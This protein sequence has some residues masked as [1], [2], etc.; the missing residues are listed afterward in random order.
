MA[1]QRRSH[2]EV[3]LNPSLNLPDN[4]HLLREVQELRARLAEAEETLLAIRSGDVDAIVV[5]GPGGDQLFTL[6]GAE[7]A[8]RALVEAMNEGAA[9][10]SAQGIVHYCNQRIADLLQ[11]PTEKIIGAPVEKLVALDSKEGFAALFANA[12]AGQPGRAELRLQAAEPVTAHVSLR[13]MEGDGPVTLCMV[14]TDLT[15]QKRRDELIAAGELAR[16][17]LASAADAIAVCDKDGIIIS[18]N[19]ALTRICGVNP[20]FQPFDTVLPLHVDERDGSRHFQPFS[21]A[22]TLAGKSFRGREASFRGSDGK[23][24]TLLLSGAQVSTPSGVAGC[25]LT[26][27]DITERKRA[28]EALRASEERWAITLQS[29][30][31]AVI[32]TDASGNI[33]FMNAL[34]EKL[35]GWTFG[36]AKSKQLDAVFQIIQEVTRIKPESPVNKV[37]R[38]GDVVGLA[39]HSLLIRRDGAE[40]PIE[41]SGAPIRNREGQIE[42]VVLVFHDVSEQRKMEHAVRTNDRLAVTGRLAATI[43]HEIHNPLDTVGSLLYIVQNTTKEEATRR[44]VS[45]AVQ[46]LSRITRMTQQMLTFQRESAQP[47]PVQIAEVLDSVLALYERKIESAAIHISKE[48]EVVR[49]ILAQPGELRQVFANVLGNA[50]EAVGRDHGKIR[51]RAY[52]SRDWR[53]RRPGVRVVVADNGRGIPADIRGKIFEP[54]FTTKGE[55]GTGLGLWITSDIIRKHDGTIRL[56]SSTRAGHSGTCFSVFFPNEDTQSG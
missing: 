34:A 13:K 28:E 15:E 14:A 25:V 12:V 47:V 23:T 33:V 6:K 22:T 50:I 40:I 31:D 29:I 49:P 16:S 48:V 24:L 18:A 4:K 39:N 9:T 2:H 46:E 41:D 10:I 30:G 44:H 11:V 21:V 51:L 20:L 37:I 27:T 43:S 38:S 53:T 56:R 55:S 54:F 26:I 45:M 35:T 7:Y 32:A 42:G 5:S 1:K 36:E 52:V 8:Y 17:I 19:D 3:P